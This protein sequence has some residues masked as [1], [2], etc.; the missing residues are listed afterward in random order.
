MDLVKLTL[1]VLLIFINYEAFASNNVGL[2][3]EDSWNSI[4]DSYY[5]CLLNSLMDSE[6][7]RCFSKLTEEQKTH[8]N[9]DKQISKEHNQRGLLFYRKN[10][11]NEAV[12]EFKKAVDIDKTNY[13]AQTNL[14]LVYIKLG[15]NIEAKREL[16]LVF[17]SSRSN[18]KWRASSA[19]NIGKIFEA[20]GNNYIAYAYYKA[21]SYVATK[22]RIETVKRLKN[23]SHIPLHP[24]KFI[25][26][27]SGDYLLF[28]INI[29]VALNP[30]TDYGQSDTLKQNYII[31][32]I[33]IYNGD[34]LQQTISNT[35][36]YDQNINY[37]DLSDYKLSD[38]KIDS[39]DFN[40]D[41]YSDFRIYIMPDGRSS[42][43][44]YYI[45][46]PDNNIFVNFK[47][48]SDLPNP[49]FD[50]KAHLITTYHPGGHAGRIYISEKYSWID[51]KLIRVSSEKQDWNGKEYYKITT[52]YKDGKIIKE[53]SEII[54]YE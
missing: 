43:Y 33:E 26:N 44:R 46:D 18:Q 23:Y 35:G 8:L 40:F 2:E 42:Y 38:L 27:N 34:R 24:I 39:L 11:Y 47:K 37:N 15:N 19:Y 54:R 28:A 51:G 31:Q 22:S 1:L 48:L 53:N 4:K 25:L 52:D 5:Q 13:E 36:Q 45:Y 30:Y 14:G 29:G 32:N 12:L 9:K 49:T 7:K 10:E 20:E 16:A 17:T 6:I 50:K 21:S 41:G 3:N